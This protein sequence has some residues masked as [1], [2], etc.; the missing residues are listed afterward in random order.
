MAGFKNGR[1][2]IVP[3]ADKVFHFSPVL[4]DLFLI[5]EFLRILANPFV[6]SPG[7]SSKKKLFG[8]FERTLY[9]HTSCLFRT[10]CRV[11]RHGLFHG[12]KG[13]TYKAPTKK[14]GGMENGQLRNVWPS[15]SVCTWRL[16]GSWNLPTPRQ[17]FNDTL[18]IMWG[19]ES[20]SNEPPIDEH[21][22]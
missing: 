22:R 7:V 18:N 6:L 16:I 9:C 10:R 15:S 21:H 17:A 19:N 8:P 20:Y 1:K 3:W 14:E 12:K 5:K 2:F 4:H 11:N 13:K